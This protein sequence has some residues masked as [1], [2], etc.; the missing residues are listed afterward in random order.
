MR[1]E[2]SAKVTVAQ[3]ISVAIGN[4]GAM[5]STCCCLLRGESSPKDT[6]SPSILQPVFLSTPTAHGS[7]FP[8][9]GVPRMLQETTHRRMLSFGSPR[10]CRW[11][12][13]T[14]ASTRAAAPAAPVFSARSPAS[15]TR[16]PIRSPPHLHLSL[17]QR[18]LCHPWSVMSLCL[19]GP[20]PQGSS[21]PVI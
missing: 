6:P 9:P 8:T 21:G 5:E 18:L 4:E 10:L 19:I 17:S 13:Q 14:A 20:I 12:L 3:V 16:S 7:H 1:R 11:F 15:V 2:K